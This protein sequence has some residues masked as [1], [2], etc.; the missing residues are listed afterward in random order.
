MS[1]AATVH[2]GENSP[3]EVAFKLMRLI[4]S[5]E[6]QSLNTQPKANREWILKTYALCLETVREPHGVREHLAKHA[7][8]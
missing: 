1:D 3:E 7:M 2:I 8:K 4:G 5:A 6:Q